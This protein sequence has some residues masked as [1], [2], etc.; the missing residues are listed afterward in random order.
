MLDFSADTLSPDEAERLRAL[1]EPLTQSVRKL[2]EA[3]AR[4]DVDA[5]TVTA[6]K[7]EI[8]SATERLSS[9]QL[10]KTW[11]LRFTTDGEWLPWTNAVVGLRNPAAPPLDVIREDTDYVWSEFSLG[12]AYEG[13][14]GHVHGGVCAMVLDHVLGEVASNGGTTRFTGTINVR[15]VR[16]TPMGALRAEARI[17][18]TEGFKAFGVAHIA[19]DQGITV[20]AEG[21]FI[22]PKWARG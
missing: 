13:P 14:P 9:K 17:V 22:Q 10:D 11:G 20:E 1:Y 19:D 15:Y 3:T 18:R 6:A 4:S 2:I 8:D 5:D 7:A 21:V 12:A 16:A